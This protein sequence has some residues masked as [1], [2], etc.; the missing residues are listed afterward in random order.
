MYNGES[1]RVV[2]IVSYNGGRQS[3]I[4][5]GALCIIR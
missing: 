4:N 5:R 3:D 2:T 1:G